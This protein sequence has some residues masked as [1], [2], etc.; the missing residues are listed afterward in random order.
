MS[1]VFYLVRSRVDGQYLVAHPK[2]TNPPAQEQSSQSDSGYLLMFQE[3]FDALSYLNT[4]GAA[5]ADRFAV[6]SIPNTQLNGLLKRW[7]FIGIGVVK[8]PL[9]PQIEFLSRTA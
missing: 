2:P 9:L 3:H 6:E 4:H 1:Q 5:V 7:G 8:D